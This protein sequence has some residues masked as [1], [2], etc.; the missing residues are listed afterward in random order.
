MTSLAEIDLI[1]TRLQMLHGAGTLSRCCRCRQAVAIV[2]RWRRRTAIQIV[3]ALRMLRVG[4]KWTTSVRE[5]EREGEGLDEGLSSLFYTHLGMLLALE[6]VGGF[7]SRS[8]SPKKRRFLA[9]AVLG[10]RLL[11]FRLELASLCP[12]TDTC[13]WKGDKRLG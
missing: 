5:R 8:V 3:G 2:T 6:M 4:Q 12:F 1:R 9:G 13:S 7:E 11:R 10:L